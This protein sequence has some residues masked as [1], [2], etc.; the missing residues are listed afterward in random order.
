MEWVRRALWVLAGFGCIA[1]GV[2]GVI[3]PG[4]PSTVFFIGAAACFSKSNERLERWVLELPKVGPAVQNYRA[5]LGMPLA[6]K[7]VAIG[8]IVVFTTI[9]VFVLGPMV[10]KVGMAAFGAVGVWYV[11]WRVPTTPHAPEAPAPI[12]TITT[13]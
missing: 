4:L 10:A 9:S 11:G 2:I 5:G 6:A 8:S 12:E 13:R 3:V 1:L 7:R